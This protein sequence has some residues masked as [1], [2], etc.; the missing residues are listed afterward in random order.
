MTTITI[1]AADVGITV[2][3]NGILSAIRFLAADRAMYQKF[4]LV[5]DSLVVQWNGVARQ[6]YNS[7]MLD[8]ATNRNGALQPPYG[9]AMVGTVAFGNLTVAACP[10]N[11]KF[12]V[13]A[14]GALP[15]AQI[16]E[17]RR[18]RDERNK[19]PPARPYVPSPVVEVAPPPPPPVDPLA[20]NALA[21][22]TR[23]VDAAAAARAV[24]T[25]PTIIGPSVEEIKTQLLVFLQCQRAKAAAADADAAVYYAARDAAIAE[26]RAEGIE[27][28]KTQD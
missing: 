15:L 28:L 1:T 24:A 10:P 3:Q 19:L 16:E 13:D 23:R 27:L 26:A 11:S 18:L 14:T 9:S 22:A 12:E 20:A 7:D 6:I 21:E 17:A 4:T 5:D 25:E 8:L 2:A